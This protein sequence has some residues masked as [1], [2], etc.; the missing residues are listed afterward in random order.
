[1][2][3]KVG[4]KVVVLSGKDK[5][6]TGT[7]LKTDKVSGRVLVEKINIATKHIK[8][9]QSG[10]QGRIV[11]VERSID[12]SNVMLVCPITQKRTRIGYTGVGKDKRRVSKKAGKALEDIARDSKKK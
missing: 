9:S 4:D 2:K 5:N 10:E 12:Q 1:M 8:K 7:V 11:K 6:K 3:I